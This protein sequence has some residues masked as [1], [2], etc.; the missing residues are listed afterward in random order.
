MRTPLE[1]PSEP[2]RRRSLRR[3]LS[4]LGVAA[5]TVPVVIAVPVFAR[6]AT[7]PHPVS[8][9]VADVAL[10]PLPA[11]RGVVADTGRRST[12]TFTLVG[13][14]WHTGS[15]PKAATIELRT[16][17]AGHWSSWSPLS[18]PDG[19]PDDGSQ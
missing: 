17:Q 2:A 11:V 18:L 5:A 15:L 4:M 1:I 3:F 14:A 13:A 10:T 16:R 12:K 9:H 7:A 19:G 8:P 6:P